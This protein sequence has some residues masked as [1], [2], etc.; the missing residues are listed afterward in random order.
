MNEPV[1]VTVNGVTYVDGIPADYTTGSGSVQNTS[2]KSGW[3]NILSSIGTVLTGIF[4]NRQPVTTQPTYTTVPQP[5][6][7]GNS[8]IIL[9]ALAVLVILFATKTIRF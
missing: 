1:I 5:Q 9:I 4:G 7:T 6:A 2:E 8:N 3:Q